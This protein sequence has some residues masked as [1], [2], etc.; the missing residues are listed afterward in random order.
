MV[1]FGALLAGSST[2][3]NARIASDPIGAL[4]DSLPTWYLIP[5]VIVAVLGLVGGAI[6][7]L[8]SSGLTLVSIGL[9]VKRHIAAGIDGA[10]M[11]L[12]TIY[13]V[14]IASNFF[15]AFQGF[16]I[17]L[18]VPLAAWSGIFVADVLMRKQPYSESDLFDRTGRYGSWNFKSIALLIVATVVGWGFVTNTFAGWLSWQ[19]Y[20]LGLLGGKNG[21]WAYT[22]IGVLFALAIGGFG[23]AVVA[24]NDV[25]AQVTNQPADNLTL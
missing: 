11:T 14:W 21:A 12:G 6:L 5:F 17:T 7:D 19:G 18:G 24:R 8:Y 3:L 22:N 2:D 9:P 25:L 1:I 20:L 4:T 23:Y 13:F 15:G 16:L 10:I